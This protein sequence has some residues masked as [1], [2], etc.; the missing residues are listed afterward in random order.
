MAQANVAAAPARTRSNEDLDGT[1]RRVK[2]RGASR[3]GLTP[4]PSSVGYRFS[5]APNIRR[6]LGSGFHPTMG[7]RPAMSHVLIH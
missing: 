2:M 3:V 4:R 7:A 6:R 5:G 1:G